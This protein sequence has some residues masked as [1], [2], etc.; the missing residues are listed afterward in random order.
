MLKKRIIP[1][2][3]LSNLNIGKVNKSIICT[4]KEFKAKI[5]T[6]SPLSQAKIYQANMADELVLIDIDRNGD[7]FNSLIQTTEQISKSLATPLAIGG[8]I[9]CIKKAELLFKSGADKIIVNTHGYKNPNLIKEIADL[10]GKQ[11]VILSIDIRKVGKEYMVY[12]NGGK[13]N[14]NKRL[15]EWAIEAERLGIGEVMITDIERDGLGRGIN[16]EWIERL[17]KLVNYPIIASGGCGNAEHFVECFNAGAA[18]VAAATYF[19]RRDQNPMQCR[20][21]IANAGIAVRT[22]N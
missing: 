11:S 6:G 12:I 13:Q 9:D 4:T 19:T 15:E 21:H 14:T 1:K 2:L 3:L 7:S 20:S 18:G 22:C 5:P 8:G 17:K 16:T 10:Y